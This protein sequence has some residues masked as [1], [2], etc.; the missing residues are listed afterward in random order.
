MLPYK[1]NARSRPYNLKDLEIIRVVL[2]GRQLGLSIAE[3]R[4]IIE[5]YLTNEEI[6]RQTETIIT[7]IKELKNTLE[8][9]DS[10]LHQLLME[11]DEL[12]LNLKSFRPAE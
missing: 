7:L 1:R 9:R 12:S 2:R 8:W 5:T 6:N 11:L 10:N 4:E 3:C